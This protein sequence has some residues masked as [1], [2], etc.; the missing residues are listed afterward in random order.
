MA[1]LVLFR[2]TMLG[3]PCCRK[4]FHSSSEVMESLP[5]ISKM[6]M[7]ILSHR[8]FDS[9]L[10]RQVQVL[11]PRMYKDPLLLGHACN[12]SLIY[13]ENEFN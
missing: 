9:S 5:S 4:N 12:E 2:I 13:G 8:E 1:F 7:K 10:N 11:Y 3:A 6:K